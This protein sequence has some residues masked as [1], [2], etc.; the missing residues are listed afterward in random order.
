MSHDHTGRHK[1]FSLCQKDLNSVAE[2]KEI[3]VGG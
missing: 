1:I 3:L 2:R